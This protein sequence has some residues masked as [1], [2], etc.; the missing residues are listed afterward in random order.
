ML[1]RNLREEAYLGIYA[2]IDINV[3]SM[4]IGREM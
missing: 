3:D 4:E 2:K 1:L